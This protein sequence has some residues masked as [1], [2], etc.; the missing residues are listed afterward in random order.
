VDVLLVYPWKFSKELVPVLRLA[1]VE[2]GLEGADVV[3]TLRAA[4]RAVGVIIVEKTEER[5]EV[6]G[7][8]D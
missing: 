8:E 7:W 4:G 5:T 2:L 3:V 1:H 6:V